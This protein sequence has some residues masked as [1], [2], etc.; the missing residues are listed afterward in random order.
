VPADCPTGK[1]RSD[2][3]RMMAVELASRQ[4]WAR[5]PSLGR[6]IAGSRLD[7]FSARLRALR[8]TDG[9]AVAA[10]RRYMS[11]IG[12]AIAKLETLLA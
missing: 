10:L 11:A 2:W 8:A 1:S 6:W 3:L 4:S 9:E 7:G 5:E 12:P